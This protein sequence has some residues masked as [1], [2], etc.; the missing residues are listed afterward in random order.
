MVQKRDEE[1]LSWGNG[2]WVWEEL[3]KGEDIETNKESDWVMCKQKQEKEG[4]GN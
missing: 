3:W 1:D 4:T 2:K